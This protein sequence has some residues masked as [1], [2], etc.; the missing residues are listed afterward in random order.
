MRLHYRILAGMALG[1]A[2]GLTA[3]LAGIAWLKAALGALE[4]VGTAFIR[5]ITMIVVPL[6]VASIISGTASLGDFK[7]LG[8]IGSKMMAFYL[9]TTCIAVVL[10]LILSHPIE[11][12]AASIRR[13]AMRSRHSIRRGGRWIAKLAQQTSFHARFPAEHHPSQSVGV[14]GAI[15]TAAAGFLLCHFRSS[16]RRYQA[17]TAGGGAEVFRRRQRG[18]DCLI[19]WMMMLAPYAVFALIAVR[20]R[21]VWTRHAEQPSRLLAHC[22]SRAGAAS[23]RSSCPNGASFRENGSAGVFSPDGGSPA[24]RIFNLVI[25]CVASARDGNG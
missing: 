14:G 13:H 11:P 17:G 2:A 18:V 20:N 15:R 23:V 3:N 19:H 5:L 7:K 12:G 9:F 25:K 10:S 6:I 4:I 16:S 8:R 24:F 1:V 22:S 21:P